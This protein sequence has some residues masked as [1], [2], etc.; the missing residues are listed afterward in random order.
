MRARILLL[1]VAVV[2]LA[3]SLQ[4][5][6]SDPVLWPERHRAFY[7]D[8]PALLLAP[9]VRQEFVHAGEVSRRRIM[10]E[11]FADPFPETPDNEMEVSIR[12]RRR[13]AATEFASPLDVRSKLVFLNG[14]PDRRLL[15]DCGTAFRPL[16]IWTYRADSGVPI[17]LADPRGEDE[18]D[19]VPLPPKKLESWSQAAHL[20]IYRPSPAQ[21]YRLWLPTDAK[22]SLFSREMEYLLEQW[23]EIRQRVKV[24]RFDLQVC[25]ETPLVDQATGIGGLFDFSK[26]RPLAEQLKPFLEPPKD[27]KEW[28][29]R[30]AAAPFPDIA[31]LPVEGLEI[32]FPERHGQRMKAR[33]VVTLPA[34]VTLGLEE[35]TKKPRHDLVIEGVLEQGGQVFEELRVRF[36]PPEPAG[37]P[38]ALVLD[39]ALRPG[40]VFLVRLRIKDEIG[41][42]VA[43]VNRGFRVPSRPTEESPILLPEEVIVALGENLGEQRTAGRDSLILIP[44][45]EEVLFGLW[46]A[47]ALVTGE[48]IQKVVFSVDDVEQ[49]TRTRA[50]FQAEVRLAE[51]PVQQIV[52]ASGYDKNGEL[53]ARDEVILNQPRGGFQVTILEPKRGY[54]GSGVT[55]VR[56]EIVVPEERRIRRVEFRINDELVKSKSSP[57]WTTSVEL[58]GA[59][60]LVYVTI[61]AVLDDERSTEAVRFVNAPGNLDEVEVTLIELYSTVVDRSNRPVRGL[62]QEQFQLLEGGRPQK[63]TK[64]EQVDNLPLTVG[65]SIDTS[66]SMASSLVQ[67]QFAGRAFLRN[68][69][70]RGDRCFVLGF[71]DQPR[72]LMPPTDD[73]DACQLGF[74]ELQA[75]GWTTLHDAVVT[76]LYYFRAFEG[77]RALI[78]LSDGDDTASDVSFRAAAEYARRSGVAIYTVGLGVSGLSL[79]IRGKLKTLAEDTGGRFFFIRNAVELADVYAEIEDELRSRYLIAYLPED[80][81]N[82]EFRRIE[83]KVKGN[84][85]KARTV[86][87]YYP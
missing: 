11:L 27:L 40:Y 64:F 84:G 6:T 49:L 30:A 19:A 32:R 7:Q 43:T 8:G 60:G 59:V 33:M 24:E 29:R 67:A 76:S 82:D 73:L 58:P 18:S 72:I 41:G 65:V 87:G 12:R 45:V 44:P 54:F 75:V 53:V 81:S 14:L 71:A 35:E 20:V 5:D 77:Q 28:A 21:P 78:L 4:G 47:E 2:L 52:E 70:K 66:G 22:R 50:P 86:R 16:E 79:E 9:S 13:L 42:A 80:P 51:F 74:D 56:A 3:W 10:E 34:D 61:T 85:L 68:V 36:R 57:P 39:R 23:L 15:I 46:R 31:E 17:Q 48:R 83:V 37:K 26:N 25:D 1:A 38:L 63:I 69:L 62:G 55:P